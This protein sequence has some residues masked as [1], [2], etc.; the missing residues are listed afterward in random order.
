MLPVI[1]ATEQGLVR[2]DEYMTVPILMVLG[3]YF[4]ETS[5]YGMVDTNMLS[6]IILMPRC[7]CGDHR[8]K[9]NSYIDEVANLLRKS[10]GGKLIGF[11]SREEKSEC[12]DSFIMKVVEYMN[13]GMPFAEALDVVK[14]TREG[15]AY[16]EATVSTKPKKR[17]W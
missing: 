12:E 8:C 2:L 15:I 6:D 1:L 17:K 14:M 4:K 3:D 5:S 7:E 10:R 9:V 13:V 11:T 16:F